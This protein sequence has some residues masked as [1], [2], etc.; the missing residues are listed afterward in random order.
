MV[1]QVVER[2]GAV[3][4]TGAETLT[5][6]VLR[7]A[8]ADPR[9]IQYRFI[10]R[11][12]HAETTLEALVEGARA[13][14]TGLR[15]HAARGPVVLLLP[16][17]PSFVLGFF[18]AVLAGALAVPVAAPGRSRLAHGLEPLRGIAADCGAG[19]VVTSR[20]VHAAVDGF[21]D[22]DDPLRALEWLQVEDLVRSRPDPG[23]VGHPDPAAPVYLQY[24]SGSTSAPRGVVVTHANVVA[25][26]RSILAAFGTGPRDHAVVW[27]PPHHD[28]GLVGGLLSPLYGGFPVTLASP[29]Q[30]LQ[31]PVRWL[32]WIAECGGTIS[33]GPDF[34]YRACVERIGDDDLEGLDLRSWRLAFTGAEPVSADT[35]EAFA[36]RFEAVGFAAEALYPCYGLAEATLMVTGADIDRPPVVRE[37][38][39]RVLDGEQRAVPATDGADVRRLVG[40]GRP[41]SGTEVRIVDPETARPCGPGEVGE[42]WCRGTSV[43]RGYFTA[44]ADDHTFDG[45]TQDGQGPFLRTGDLGFVEEGELFVTGRRKDVIIVNGRNLDANDVEA[46]IEEVVASARTGTIAAISVAD[47]HEQLAIVVE[48]RRSEADVTQD[49]RL[50]IQRELGT[51][52]GIR[53]DR[54]LFVA[55]GSL[56]RTTS[57]KLRRAEVARRVVER[58]LPIL[59]EPRDRLC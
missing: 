56:P 41:V 55:M 7:S 22:P 54:V 34:A 1:T 44:R 49:L 27:L 12:D 36:R 30:F 25:N 52:F 31:S 57:G 35:L 21:L 20:Q 23:V 11:D 46:A 40:C 28:M 33:G 39:R 2:D 16:P 32:R 48:A 26:L 50:A 10:G 13:V 47:G 15:P 38:S 6:L 17:G 58:D 37:V 24:T 5:E 29:H 43:S 14:A 9:R 42:I 3:V 18:G 45:R 51:R 53:A 59:D 4:E 8:E 19:S